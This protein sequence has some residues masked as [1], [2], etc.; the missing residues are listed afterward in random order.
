MTKAENRAAA[1]A[2]LQEQPGK[3]DEEAR[4]AADLAELD[5]LRRYLIFNRRAYGADA[6]KLRSAIDDYV[7]EP[8]GDR[9]DCSPGIIAS[10]DLVARVR[11]ADRRARWLRAGGRFVTPAS[12]N[13][14]SC[15]LTVCWLAA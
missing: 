2:Y 10:D 8:T 9:T 14:P 5:R 13:A 11:R 7:E 1:R 4:I 3:L 12:S 6:D 15:G